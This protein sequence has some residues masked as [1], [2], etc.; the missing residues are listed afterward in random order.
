MK[1]DKGPARPAAGSVRDPIGRQ[2]ARLAL[3]GVL[4]GYFALFRAVGGHHAWGKLG[5]GG[6]PFWF[7]DL[8]NVTAAWDCARHGIAVLPANPCDPYH[9]PANY[10]RLWVLLYHLGLGQ[11][12]TF[13]LGLVVCGL[14]LCAAVAVLPGRASWPAT[15]IYALLLLSPATMI[16]VERG[17]VDLL[18][19]AFVAA[20][21][22]ISRRGLLGLVAGDC[23][24]GLSAALKLFPIFATGFLV[25]R[26]ER[27]AVLSIVA[28]VVSFA[29][30][31][32]L[33]RHELQQIRAALPEENSYSYGIRRIS[34]WVSAGTEGARA[35][36]ASLPAWDVLLMAA[37]AACGWLAARKARPRIVAAS[38]DRGAVRDLDLFWAGAC[39]YVGTYALARNFDYRLVFCLLTVPQLVR[40]G[41]AGSKL[42]YGALAALLGTMWLDAGWFAWPTVHRVIAGWEGWTVVGPKGD[43]LPLAA[44]S[45]LLLCWALIGLLVASAPVPLSPSRVRLRRARA[46]PTA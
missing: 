43:T 39:V 28:L 45:Q 42:A 14:F 22:M 38:S 25:P 37:V 11:G 36:R 9:R 1:G 29:V 13:A 33:I 21:V 31:A 18:L 7:G 23:L 32:F 4:L 40:W 6:L 19:F 46:L 5:V 10:P 2:R 34:D 24:V 44:I 27:R 3:V 17:N 16:G 35:S 26:R 41:A 12:D 20:G 8:R 15:V 30:Y